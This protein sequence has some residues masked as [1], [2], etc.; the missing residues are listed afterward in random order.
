[1][2]KKYKK[3]Y[4]SILVFLVIFLCTGFL[5]LSKR[6]EKD[7]ITYE[8][9]T[10]YQSDLTKKE[11]YKKADQERRMQD[12]IQQMTEDSVPLVSIDNFSTEDSS[13]TTVTITLKSSYGNDIP[14]EQRENIE[15]LVSGYF[16]GIPQENIIINGEEP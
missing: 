6:T 5:A 13:D 9:F 10:E 11:E 1:M 3:M 12:V 14:K 8:N 15:N 2:S 16:S 4:I 7:D